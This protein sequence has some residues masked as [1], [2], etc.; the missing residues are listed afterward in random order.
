MAHSDNEERKF[1]LNDRRAARRQHRPP[2]GVDGRRRR[3]WDPERPAT[4]HLWYA[5]HRAA[6]HSSRGGQAINHLAVTCASPLRLLALRLAEL[7]T[8]SR[9]LNR[10]WPDAQQPCQC[11]PT[12]RINA[13]KKRWE[14]IRGLLKFLHRPDLARDALV[15]LLLNDGSVV[16]ATGGKAFLFGDVCVEL[17]RL[18]LDLG[19]LPLQLPSSLRPAES[20]ALLEK[21]V[22]TGIHRLIV[23]AFSSP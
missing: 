1:R 19:Q 2:A 21:S 13:H 10:P 22:A 14:A 4:Q 20:A 23:Q 5:D 16:R 6:R 11:K 8:L 12:L 9:R 3:R 18:S 17:P 7:R 15:Y